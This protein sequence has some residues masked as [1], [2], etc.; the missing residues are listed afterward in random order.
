[1]LALVTTWQATDQI[2]VACRFA[3]IAPALMAETSFERWDEIRET[4]RWEALRR[5]CPDHKPEKM[6]LRQ[7]FAEAAHVLG[8]N[9]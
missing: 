3:L 1:M 7:A 8:V 6:S 9:T 4:A 5:R 2:A